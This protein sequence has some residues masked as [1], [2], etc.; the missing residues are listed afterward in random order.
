MNLLL[1]L[2]FLIGFPLLAAL[3]LLVAKA[4]GF[5]D[6]VVRISALVIAVGSVFLCVKSF[7]QGPQFFAFHNEW[8]DKGMMGIEILIAIFIT[9]LSVKHKKILAPVLSWCQLILMVWFETQ[10]AHG[11]EV[12]KT[13]FFDNFSVIMALIIGIIGSVICVYGLGYMKDFQHHHH[14]DPDRRPLFFFLMFLFLAAMF[15]IVFSNHIIWLYFFWEITTLC[16][17]LLIGYTRTEE[18]VTNSFRAINYN[19][20]G[21]LGFAIGIV[22]LG[23]NYGILELDKMLT[24][25]GAGPAIIVVALAFSFAGI[26]KSAQLPFSGWLLGAMVAPTPTSA[27]LHSSTM[28]KAG[29]YLVLR[30]SPLLLGNYAGVIVAL[31]G[32]IT[33]M[34]A[35][36][37]AISQ[38][39]AKRVLAWSTV[40]NLGLIVACGGIGTYEAVWAGILL[41]I[42]HAVAKSLLFLSVGTVEHNIGSRDIEDMDNLI[43]R[44]PKV[45]LM[46][47][48]GIMGMFLAPFGMLISKWAA[49]KAFVD[50]R[51]VLIIVMLAFGSAATLFFWTKWLGKLIAVSSK[52]KNQ[53][54]TVH[55]DE[56]F[57]LGLHALLVIVV[58]F[59]FPLISSHYLVPYLDGTF[60]PGEIGLS[61]GNIKIM[62]MMLLMLLLLPIG[63]LFY[64]KEDKVVN[65]YLAGRNLPEDMNHSYKGS[66]N[67]NIELKLSNY[68]LEEFF[69]EKKLHFIGVVVTSSIFIFVLSVISAVLLNTYG[70]GVM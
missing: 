37:I 22:V 7:G 27:L 40:A 31:I 21:G 38:S 34:L 18:A 29:V 16:S 43:S 61:A 24:L 44:M 41:V 33:F 70:R 36:F 11:I 1:P 58:C 30:M 51:N 47:V 62:S 6:L 3:I 59:G 8:I 17:F 39:N 64:G 45:A 20:I 25:A 12:E 63:L 54:A 55:K 28:V 35:S 60:G 10:H 65:V 56:W 19:L 69:G 52:P 5:R 68:Y 66:I 46:M 9:Y 15:G 26:A 13:L 48:V 2:L 14:D 53:E 67:R 4:D 57:A 50:T 42:F 23:M 32:T 49:L